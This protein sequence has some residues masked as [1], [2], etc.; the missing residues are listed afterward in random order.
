MKSQP[1]L[2]HL[3]VVVL[4]SSERIEDIKRSYELG[5]FSF[6]TK[7]AASKISSALQ[8]A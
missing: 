2:K 7:H 8:K 3:Q 1:H 6:L 4:T 5:A